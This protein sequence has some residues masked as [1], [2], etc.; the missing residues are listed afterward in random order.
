MDLMTFLSKL[1]TLIVGTYDDISDHNNNDAA[2]FLAAL[3]DETVPY[4][5]VLE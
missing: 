5:W 2:L 3:D 4:E 1:S